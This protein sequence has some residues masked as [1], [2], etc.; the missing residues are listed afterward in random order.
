MDD[1]AALRFIKLPEVMSRTGLSRSSIYRRISEGTFPASRRYRGGWGT[2]WTSV[3]VERWQAEQV[4][5]DEW[6]ALT[7]LQLPA[8]EY[9]ALLG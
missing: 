4:G 3:E 1:R 5:V 6:V 9:D 7:E 2:F 8:D